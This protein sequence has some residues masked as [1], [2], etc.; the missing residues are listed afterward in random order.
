[1]VDSS[2]EDCEPLCAEAGGDS[3]A[4]GLEFLKP[5]TTPAVML[6]FY[7]AFSATN[8][9]LVPT[10]RNYHHVTTSSLIIIIFR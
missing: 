10:W 6:V 2:D 8:H 7:S 5:G 9:K 1:M 4:V 3:E